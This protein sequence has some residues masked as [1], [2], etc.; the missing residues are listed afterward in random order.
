MNK[1]WF[2]RLSRRHLLDW[3]PDSYFVSLEYKA[4]LG[5]KLNLSN[6]KTFNEK[7]Q[8]LKIHDHRPEYTVMVD[9][10]EAKDY[11]SH[12]IG[13]QYIIPTLGVWN[14]FEDIDFAQLPNQFVLKCTHDSG[15]TSI[16]RD[17]NTW[18]KEAARKKISSCLQRKYFYCH[19]EWPYKNV[20]PRIIAEKYMQDQGHQELTDY[21]FFCFNGVPQYLSVSM[22]MENHTTACSAFLTMDW[23]FNSFGRTDYRRMQTL[24]PK[25]AGFDE[26]GEIARK[27]SA[28]IPFLRIDLYFINQKI[29]F[30]ELT[31]TPC[32]G[33]TP[34]DPPEAD[35]E[36][37]K[38]LHIDHK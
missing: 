16:C 13:K 25:P 20:K 37:G 26:M 32:A 30:G 34:F 33:M 24:P 3:L 1:K 6:P 12:K 7:L 22:G 23:N 27:L 17:K 14:H 8:W 31:F 29:F 21:K 11:V 10:Y 28:G 4:I 2:S 36:V 9:K 35:L 19:R 5:K 18:D 15:G 38:L